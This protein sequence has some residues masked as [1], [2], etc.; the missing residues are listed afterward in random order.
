MTMESQSSGDGKSSSSRA[1]LTLTGALL[2]L[3]AVFVALGTWQVQRLSW[4][5]DLIARVDAR[6]HAETVPAPS[7]PDWEYVTREKD[8]YR[9]VSA[10][11]TFLHGKSV[12]VQAVTERGAGF[13]VLTPM[14]LADG[15]TILINRGFVPSDRRDPAARA[16]GE[17]VGTATVTGLLRITEPGGAFLRSNDPANDRW[18]SRDVAAIAASKAL[19]DV[20]PYFV[21]ADA[22]PNPGG[23]PIGGLTVVRFRNSHF[24]YALT[25]FALAAMSAA[26]VWIVYR[27]RVA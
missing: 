27:R 13:W 2:F 15:S 14:I 22:S 25:W 9:R 6:V 4:K 16:Q 20:A 5:L 24:V 8:E 3:V 10:I 18:F 7:R 19:S 11:G 23:L 17:I 21:D 12:L 1:R 26:G